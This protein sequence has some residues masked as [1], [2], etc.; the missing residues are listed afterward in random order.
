MQRSAAS[1]HVVDSL[2]L[3]ALALGMLGLLQ[4]RAFHG[5]DAQ[6]VLG[7]VRDGSAAYYAHKLYMPLMLAWHDLLA[8]VTQSPFLSLRAASWCGVALGTVFVHRASLVS[9]LERGPAAMAAALTLVAPAVSFFGTVVELHGPFHAFA[10]VAFW[11]WARC[12]QR[13]T[14]GAFALLGLATACAAGMHSTGHLLLGLLPMLAL[15]WHGM[16]LWRHWRHWLATCAAHGLASLALVWILVPLEA[17]QAS[18]GST[19]EDAFAY[20][21]PRL[22]WAPSEIAAMLWREWGEPYLPLSLISLAALCA[23]AVRVRA[24]ALLLGIVPFWGAVWVLLRNELHER[25]AYLIPF[26]WPAAMLAVVWL[27]RALRW[28]TLAVS[29]ALAVTAIVRH[30]HVDDDPRLGASLASELGATPAFVICAQVRDVE[31]VFRDLPTARPWPI[32]A[33]AGALPRGYAALCAEFDRAVTP[34]LAA[35]RLVVF[36]AGALELLRGLAIPDVQRFVD[37]HLAQR[38]VL[39]AMGTG[40]WQLQRR[41]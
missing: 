31:Q 11:Q 15:G 17:R 22:P 14:V 41:A 24:A 32:M 40:G 6:H 4:Q 30:D 39:E 12:M 9:G 1:R 28:L 37:E 25:G 21:W 35:G 23:R 33:L 16:R 20:F 26:A 34:E 3:G 7:L 18:P 5:M 10:G 36:S 2:A 38:Y 13:P 8:P 29:C 19:F 27:P